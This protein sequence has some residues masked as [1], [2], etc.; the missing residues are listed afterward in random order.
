MSPADIIAMAE[1]CVTCDDCWNEECERLNHEVLLNPNT[2]LRRIVC[3]Q[4]RGRGKSSAYL[5][6]YTQSEWAE[7]GE[8]FQDDYLAGH[9]DRT[10][11]MCGG[12]NVVDELTDEAE[13]RPAIRAWLKEMWECDAMEAMERRMGA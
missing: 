12:A 8:D 7:Q 3:P 5:G 13:A 2:D 11:D 4:C 10:C 9:Y 1:W 6:A